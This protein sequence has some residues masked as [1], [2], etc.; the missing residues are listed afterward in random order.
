MEFENKIKEL[1]I[2]SGMTQKQLA[3]RLGVAKSVVSYYEH[4][5]RFPSYDVLIKLSQIFHVTTDYLLNVEH[6][7]M[8]DVS[9]L[10]EEQI[11]AIN[12]LINVMSK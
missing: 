4:G 2:E 10:N 5:E 12:N 11:N 1:R 7:R 9:G 8:L 6:D 3:E